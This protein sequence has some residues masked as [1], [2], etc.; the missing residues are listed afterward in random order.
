MPK[1]KNRKQHTQKVNQFKNKIKTMNQEQKFE[2]PEVRSIPIW[3]NEATIG[4]KGFEWEVI[5]N[6]LMQLQTAQQAANAIMSRNIVEGVIKLDFEKF[7]K[8]TQNYVPM[9]DEEKV[10]YVEDFNKRIEAAKRPQSNGIIEPDGL[11][12][13]E[14]VPVKAA[15]LKKA[16]VGVETSQAEVKPKATRKPRAAK[17]VKMDTSTNEVGPGN[18]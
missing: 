1:S 17:V 2:I 3:D 5:F 15:D 7:D 16:N 14:G 10:P 6:S 4:M 12:T 13:Q 18:A 9:T 11:V 8:T